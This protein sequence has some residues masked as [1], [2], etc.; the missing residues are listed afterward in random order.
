M[1]TKFINS[2]EKGGFGTYHVNVFQNNRIVTEHHFR[3][4]DRENLYSGSKTVVA[5][6][7]G[8]AENE[9]LLTTEDYVLDY[10][11]DFVKIAA[12]GSDEIKI[13]HLLQ[14]SSGHTSE[15]FDRYNE[16]DR[17][18]LFFSTELVNRL[19]EK[20]YY[21]DLCS[22]MLGRIIE[23]ISGVNLL[24]YLKPRLFDKLNILN[25]QWHTCQF[26]HTSCSGGLFLNI[27]EFSRM[28]IL[29]VNKGVYDNYIIV[30]KDFVDR[31]VSDV[32]D[33]SYKRNDEESQQGYRYQIWKC[34][35]HN[36]YRADG[37]Y[38]QYCI[39]L[40]DYNAVVTITGHYEE[41][42]KDILRAVWSDIEP[43]L[44]K[45][46]INGVTQNIR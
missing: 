12:T 16:V 13:R 7:V 18:E 1:L 40:Y 19:G 38:G 23:R 44:S 39:V 43:F 42:N 22:Y 37:M 4:N 46:T 17:A 31:M 15:S 10:F 9:G 32:I 26:G 3:S 14:M 20:H 24:E 36:T 8:I 28:G 25:P 5:I 27:E 41:N 21:E 30:S 11:P 45:N 6:G 2:I 34:T 35:L 33:T 29:L